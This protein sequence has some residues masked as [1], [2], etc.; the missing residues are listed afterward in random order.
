MLSGLPLERGGHSNS[1]RSVFVYA[2][3]VSCVI[4]GLNSLHDFETL[5]FTL[6]QTVDPLILHHAESRL[7]R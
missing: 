1:K 5:E 2:T 7:L 4:K 3:T 6:E